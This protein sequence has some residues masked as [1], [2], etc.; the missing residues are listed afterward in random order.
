MCWD[1]CKPRY[2]PIS[3]AVIIPCDE[4]GSKAS[5]ASPTATQRS[6]IRCIFSNLFLSASVEVLPEVDVDQDRRVDAPEELGPEVG[7]RVV[8]VDQTVVVVVAVEEAEEA[9]EAEGVEE[10]LNT[11][12]IMCNRFKYFYD[13]FITSCAVYHPTFSRNQH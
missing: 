7:Q 12:Q 6:F 2:I 10:G 13:L 8:V 4:S 3:R 1:S 5:A 9:E 11:G